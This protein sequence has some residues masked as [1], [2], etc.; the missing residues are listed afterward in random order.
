MNIEMRIFGYFLIAMVVAGCSGGV[1]EDQ[2]TLAKKE[3][4]E[5]EKAFQQ[6]AREKGLRDAFVFYADENAA[7]IRGE[8][9]IKGKKAIQAW[10]D[11]RSGSKMELNWTPDFVEVSSSGDLGYTY[12]RYLMVI[13]DS[14]GVRKEGKGIFHTVWKKQPDGTWK[15]VWD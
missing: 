14:N 1:K 4:L 9:L 2:K 12:G 3:I 7:I 10:Y 8:R 6:M 15:Y 11:K 13:T 5:A